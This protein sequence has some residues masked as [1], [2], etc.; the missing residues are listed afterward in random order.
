MARE[1]FASSASPDLLVGLFQ[2]QASAPTV[3]FGFENYPQQM[4][5]Y[6]FAL[7]RVGLRQLAETWLDRYIRCCE[8]SEVLAGELTTLL[9]AD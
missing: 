4:L 5:A 6:A 2:V 9:E 1:F 7:K 3:R 8:M